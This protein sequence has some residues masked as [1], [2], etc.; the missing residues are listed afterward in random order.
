MNVH[1]ETFTSAFLNKIT[2]FEYLHL[3]EDD[4]QAIVDQYMKM[5][6]AKFAE[7]C[8]YDITNGDDISRQFVLDGATEMEID[9]IVDIVSEGMVMYWMKP[10]M[11]KQENLEL[12]LNN[13]D[14]SSYSP[15]ELTKQVKAVYVDCRDHFTNMVNE[16]SYRHGDLSDLHL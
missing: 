9:E 6:C 2:E 7:V 14:F 13:V 12:M 3:Q 10:M 11:Y 5:A 15:A 1:Y 16:Y 4:R 8:K